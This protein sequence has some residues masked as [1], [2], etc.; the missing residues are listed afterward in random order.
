M[1]QTTYREYQPE[2]KVL[3]LKTPL[4]RNRVIS[5][6]YGRFPKRTNETR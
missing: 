1:N 4:S 5:D 3:K 2:V 6:Y